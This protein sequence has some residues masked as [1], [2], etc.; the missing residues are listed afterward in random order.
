M[1][2]R[3]RSNTTLEEFDKTELVEK[4]L[5]DKFSLWMLRIIIKLDGSKK[6]LNKDNS[7]ERDSIA[8]FLDVG[9]YTEMDKSDFKRNEVL[10]ILKENLAKL[11]KRNDLQVL[12]F[13]Q[14]I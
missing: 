7:F 1:R 14:K 12:N 4:E 10:M 11:E 2:R 3:R 6:F 8:C 13:L 9:K 5:E